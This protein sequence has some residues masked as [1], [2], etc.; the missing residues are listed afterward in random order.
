MIKRPILHQQTKFR[1]DRSN[2]CGD[3]E[4]FVNVQDGGRRHLDFSKIQNFNRYPLPGA[5]V[6]Q[7]AKFG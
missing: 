2:H 3:I 7:H 6:R 4:I 1:K 5:S